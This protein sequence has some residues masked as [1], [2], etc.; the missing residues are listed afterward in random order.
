MWGYFFPAKD[1]LSILPK[2]PG[3][4]PLSYFDHVKIL[5]FGKMAF[6]KGRSSLNS[7]VI[8]LLNTIKYI[9]NNTAKI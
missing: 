4:K 9:L 8:Y 5:M 3:G 1:L 6:F 2:Q 7:V